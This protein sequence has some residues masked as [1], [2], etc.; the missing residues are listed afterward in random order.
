MDTL[1]IILIVIG[2]LVVIA[3]IA[4]LVQRSRGHKQEQRRQGAIE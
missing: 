2:A 1:E 3:I 4:A